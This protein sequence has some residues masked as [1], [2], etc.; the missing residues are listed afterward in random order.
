VLD[1][2]AA[3]HSYWSRRVV[4]RTNAAIRR[5]LTGMGVPFALIGGLR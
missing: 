5:C 1:L 2:T 3:A 4:R